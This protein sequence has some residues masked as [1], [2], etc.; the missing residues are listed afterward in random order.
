MEPKEEK[1]W[2]KYDKSK[3][4]VKSG[5]CELGRTGYVIYVD[6]NIGC[7]AITRMRD[8]ASCVVSPSE[9]FEWQLKHPS[10]YMDEYIARSNDE[11][12]DDR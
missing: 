9:I 11:D 1:Y 7:I 4:Y 5:F 12:T 3:A 2:D 8:E 10:N 6:E